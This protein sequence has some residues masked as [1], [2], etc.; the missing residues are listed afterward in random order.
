LLAI[1]GKKL[2]VKEAQVV[3]RRL[4]LGQFNIVHEEKWDSQ[5]APSLFPIQLDDTVNALHKNF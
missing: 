3:E 5:V 1:V 4:E 2:F